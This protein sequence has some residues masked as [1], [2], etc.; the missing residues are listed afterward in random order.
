MRHFAQKHP[1]GAKEK[2]FRISVKSGLIRGQI[3]KSRMGQD[4]EK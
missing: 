3:F 4:K 1:A 2:S